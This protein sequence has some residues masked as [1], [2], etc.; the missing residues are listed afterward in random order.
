M[1]QLDQ[2]SPSFHADRAL[3]VE[4][5]LHSA[6]SAILYEVTKAIDE[7]SLS[8]ELVIEEVIDQFVNCLLHYT[9]GILTLRRD[10][11]VNYNHFDLSIFSDNPDKE[12]PV[13]YAGEDKYFISFRYF[14]FHLKSA[15]KLG[16][17]LLHH[18]G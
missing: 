15:R 4:S 9:F 11:G 10:L 7:G 6:K 2:P 16:I 5:N 17:V 14:L 1:L 3:F 12:P 8:P 13:G 18:A